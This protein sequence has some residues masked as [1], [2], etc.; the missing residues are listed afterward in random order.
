MN[1][2]SPQRPPHSAAQT[3]AQ[4]PFHTTFHSSRNSSLE[5]GSLDTQVISLRWVLRL[6]WAAIF[7]QAVTALVVSLVL[8]I[9]LPL[10]PLAA[11]LGLAGITNL[12]ALFAS[13]RQ[14]PREGWVA[15]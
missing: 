5:G 12:I 9:S 4:T 7:G 15:A 13:R 10:V 14:S 3:P 1:A 6:R 2:S 8:G 11:I